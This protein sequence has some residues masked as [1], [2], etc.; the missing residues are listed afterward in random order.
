M[1]HN[2]SCKFLSN[3]F[4]FEVDASGSQIHLKPCCKW[5]NGPVIAIRSSPQQYQDYRHSIGNLDS[6]NSPWCNLCQRA[7]RV[8]AKSMRQFAKDYLPDNIEWGDPTHVE[9]QFDTTCNAACIMCGP[10]LSSLWR[11]ELRKQVPISWRAVNYDPVSI[12]LHRIDVQKIRRV[13]FIG[14]EPMLNDDDIK[15]MQAIKQPELV[16]LGYATNGSIMPTVAKQRLWSRFKQVNLAISIDGIANRFEYV[17]YPLKW[18]A[19]CRNIDQ[20]RKH[21]PSNVSFSINFTANILNFYYYQ[22]FYDWFKTTGLAENVPIYNIANGILDPTR[23][24]KKLAE[25]IYQ[26]YDSEHVVSQTIQCI[27]Q[28]QTNMLTYINQLDQRRASNWKLVFP[29]IA[30]CFD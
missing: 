9:F 14:G 25:K 15:L 2:P 20:M 24:S 27:D 4:K 29:D 1:N 8:G 10:E 3:G 26:K 19:I 11:Q 22:E 5:N 12:I 13:G 28:N 23:V 7:E 18:D 21:L 17:R 16:S 30:D 6:T